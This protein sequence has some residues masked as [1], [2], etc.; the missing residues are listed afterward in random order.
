MYISFEVQFDETQLRELAAV[1]YRPWRRLLVMAGVGAGVGAGFS[2]AAGDGR[3]MVGGF[4]GAWAALLLLYVAAWTVRSAVTRVPRWLY[5]PTKYL[6]DD[7]GVTVAAPK[8]SR[9]LSWDTFNQVRLTRRFLLLQHRAVHTVAVPL[10]GLTPEQVEEI[11]GKV[12]GRSPD[13]SGRPLRPP[14]PDRGE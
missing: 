12:A 10:S 8:A 6:L 3:A 13:A 7:A 5:A 9:W 14:V 1:T 4:L 2:F 11:R